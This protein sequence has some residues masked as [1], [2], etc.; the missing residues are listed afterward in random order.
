[1]NKSS[2]AVLL[3]DWDNLAGAIMGR[4]KV[5]ERRQVDDLWTYASQ[6]SGHQL[7]HAH[8]AATRFDKTIANAMR[9]HMIEPEE[10]RS[11]KEQADIALTVLAM[12]YLHADAGHFFLVTGDQDFIPLITRLHSAGCQ[13]TVIFGDRS[14]LSHELRQV[15]TGP[16]LESV[17]I[18]DLT[19][20]RERPPNTGGRALLGLL[21]LQRRGFILGGKETGQRTA[22]LREWGL[23]E[24]D[25]ET[26]YWS[27][28]K[29]ITEK[30]PRNDAAY[31]GGGGRWLPRSASRTYLRL[32]AEQV[33]DIV[34]ADHA[35]RWVSSR[36]RGL[37]MAGL[38]T[39]P[40]RL[41]DG[42]L[43]DRTL[44]ALLAVRLMRRDADETFSLVDKPLKLGYLEQLWRV[45]AAVNAECYRRRAATIPFNQLES[46]LTR[47]GV[48]QGEDQRAASRIREA[49]NYAKAAGVVDSVAV[50]E[51]RHVLVPHSP[52]S[53]PF[54]QAYH[55]L[56][57]AFADRIDQPVHEAEV[58]GAMEACD[59]TRA[60]PHFG[61]DLRDRQRVLRI[62]TQSQLITW[63]DRSVTIAKSGWG[64]TGLEL[65][66]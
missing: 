65:R 31:P 51:R 64:E 29:T 54:E 14:R 45:F 7:R 39:G 58:L 34:A 62:L 1:M 46:L 37:T 49:V 35:I 32:S 33:T 25:D 60:V 5:I 30:V 55:E 48:G 12:D 61:F 41:D 27:L 2:V 13:V 44:D 26:Q 22:L 15:L 20:L 43:L 42:A 57:A 23:I 38:R 59:E 53:R 19:P 11:V 9:D 28:V 16:G 8:M 56:Y 40:F 18:G 52:L 21:E 4:G 3:I 24:N 47:R 6:H 10:V 63:K 17:D 66:T 36:G 50:N